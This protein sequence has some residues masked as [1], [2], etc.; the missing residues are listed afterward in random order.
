[1]AKNNYILVGVICQD[2]VR[3][4]VSEGDRVLVEVEWSKYKITAA[5]AKGDYIVSNVATLGLH[6]IKKGIAEGDYVVADGAGGQHKVGARPGD[7]AEGD[8]VI[9]DVAV[10]GRNKVTSAIAEFDQVAADV[11]VLGLNIVTSAIAE[12]DYVV[13][14]VAARDRQGLVWIVTV[15]VNPHLGLPVSQHSPDAP[16]LAGAHE[17]R[18]YFYLSRSRPARGEIG[19]A[20]V[21]VV[22]RHLNFQGASTG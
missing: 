12:G 14:D 20:P 17:A 16:G 7:V 13:A 6:M 4:A 15:N 11:A 19:A 10:I 9:T 5:V 8:F 18:P 2:G 3:L 22:G 21:K 1:M